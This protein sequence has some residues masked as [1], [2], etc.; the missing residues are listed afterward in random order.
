M[1][2]RRLILALLVLVVAAPAFAAASGCPEP[3]D[4]MRREHMDLLRHDRDQ[5][6]R[7]G[8]HQPG[9]GLKDC[10]GCHAR[11]DEAGRAVPVSEP[12]HFCVGCHQSAAVTLDCF[13]C[14]RSTPA[15][16][17]ASP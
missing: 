15:P 13:T 11:R 8:L 4:R 14:H 6:V 3:P 10:I 1:A 17:E 5:A 2:P 7:L 9:R 12:S 16:T